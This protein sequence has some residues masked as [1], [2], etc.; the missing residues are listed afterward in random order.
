MR[1]SDIREA[2]NTLYQK[3][4]GNFNPTFVLNKEVLEITNEIDKY[5]NMCEHKYI[6]G[7]CIY[8]DKKEN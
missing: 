7:I 6:N 5:R 2:I 1:Q 8:C 4:E 3:L